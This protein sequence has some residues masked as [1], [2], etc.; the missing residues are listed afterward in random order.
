MQRIRNMCFSFY[1]PFYQKYT[2]AYAIPIIASERVSDEAIQRACYVVRVML[3]DRRDLRQEMYK[4]Y[5]RVAILAENELTIHIPEHSHLD[6]SY[7][8]R[9]RSIGGEVVYL[10]GGC[11]RSVIPN[12]AN[13]AN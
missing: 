4:K 3:A 10:E 12:Y 1:S 11:T 9:I 5:M 13:Y 2:N 8:E 7:N 6:E